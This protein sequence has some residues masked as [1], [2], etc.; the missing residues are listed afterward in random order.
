MAAANPDL[1]A[2]GVLRNWA[3]IK[4]QLGC[5]FSCVP[6][7]FWYNGSA[8]FKDYLPGFGLIDTHGGVCCIDTGLSIK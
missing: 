4:R 3:V 2:C 1:P 7:K 8:S 6:A 5:N